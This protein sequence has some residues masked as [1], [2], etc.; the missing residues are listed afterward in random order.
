VH[1]VGRASEVLEV[2]GD[3]LCL[4]VGLAQELAGVLGFDPAEFLGV[5]IE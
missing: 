5:F 2:F 1:L 4:P 3:V